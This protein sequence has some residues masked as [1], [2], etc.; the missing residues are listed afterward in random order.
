[1]PSFSYPKAPFR[2]IAMSMS[3]G[4]YRAAAFHLGSLSY[5]RHIEFQGRPLIENVKILSTISGGTIT[6]VLYAH[7]LWSAKNVKNGIHI[8]TAEEFKAYYHKMLC[9]MGEEDLIKLALTKM[10]DDAQW[11]N[12]T[13]KRTLINAFA[14][15]Y[16]EVFFEEHEQKTFG[17]FWQ[18]KTHLEEVLFNATEFD[19][20]RD[21]RFKKTNAH[22]NNMSGNWD[23]AIPVAAAQEIR[24][25]D[26]IAASS[27]FPGGFEPIAFPRDFIT[28]EGHLLAKM[29]DPEQVKEI[30]PHCFIEKWLFKKHPEKFTYEASVGLMDGGIVDNQG[31][32]AII[33]SGEKRERAEQKKRIE[34]LGDSEWLE[35]DSS[36][37]DLIIISDVS[38][39][40]MER[41]QL[42]DDKTVLTDIG[43]LDAATIYDTLKFTGWISVLL[44]IALLVHWLAVPYLLNWVENLL[45]AVFASIGIFSLGSWLILTYVDRILLKEAI[46][47]IFQPY[48]SHFYNLN[49][50]NLE[51]LIKDRFVSVKSMVTTVFMN[52]IRRLIYHKI[53]NNPVWEVRRMTNLVYDLST[54]KATEIVEDNWERN[55]QRLRDKK[56]AINYPEVLTHITPK[57]GEIAENAATMGTSLWF[58]AEERAN[59]TGKRDKLKDL[60]VAGQFTIC[61]NLLRYICELRAYEAEY[62]QLASKDAIDDLYDH[63]LLDWRFFNE[64]NPAWLYDEFEQK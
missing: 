24:L 48:L 57:V 58:T 42:A 39:P 62:N 30:Y 17:L 3:G 35:E 36:D 29:T 16:Q 25:G 45:L 49:I 18:G 22:S 8:Q 50:K 27:C 9:F 56:P 47:P 7:S 60:V 5:L 14:K 55:K 19:F 38:S 1:M 34:E 54:E 4:G 44:L 6:G 10:A 63:L 2:D 52:Q 51:P 20:G 59:R 15:V 40:K 64:K 28:K 41:L 26:I 61:Y 11:V 32:E 37:I 33:K 46:P 53:Y 23:R 31:I 12:E 13:K 43:G 21:F